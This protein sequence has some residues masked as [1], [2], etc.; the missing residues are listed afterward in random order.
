[1]GRILL[2]ILCLGSCLVSAEQPERLKFVSS[3]FTGI[4]ELIEQDGK[5]VQ[6]GLGVDIVNKIAQMLAIKIDIEILPFKRALISMKNKKHDAIFGVYKKADREAYLD[7][8]DVV[9]FVDNYLFYGNAVATIDWDGRMS[10]Y[11]KHANLGWI[12]GWSYFDELYAMKDQINKI[13]V[14]NLESELRML[15]KGRLDLAVGPIRDINPL[16]IKLGMEK[17]LKLVS[18][19]HGETG[20]FIAFAKG[21][22]SELQ[23]KVRDALIII[24][25]MPWYQKRLKYYRLDGVL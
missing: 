8:I 4:S 10:S 9:F 12:T 21:R 19:G 11:P 25:E 14:N 1:M 13:Q 24:M 5:M 2:L 18:A 22:H 17:D 3:H 20:N 6:R 15:K 16:I 7:F 23:L